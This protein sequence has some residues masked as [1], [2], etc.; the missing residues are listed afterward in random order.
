MKEERTSIPPTLKK[1]GRVGLMKSFSESKNHKMIGDTLAKNL[2][3][4][5]TTYISKDGE[6]SAEEVGT[7]GF[8][9]SPIDTGYLRLVKDELGNY[10]TATT[11]VWDGDLDDFDDHY[12]SLDDLQ[13]PFTE[14][15]AKKYFA[16]SILGAWQYEYA[17]EGVE[18]LWL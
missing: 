1:R 7:V 8:G 15:E 13:G 14:K 9:E 12:K 16:D 5:K 4:G 3:T 11:V 2:H 10:Y 18:E 6:K 17:K